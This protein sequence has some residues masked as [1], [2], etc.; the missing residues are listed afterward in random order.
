MPYRLAKLHLE[1]TDA[2]IPIF[3]VGGD[4]PD[5]DGIVDVVTVDFG[6][7]ATA[8]QRTQADAIIAAHD[9]TDTNKVTLDNLAALVAQF[10][11]DWDEIYSR[12]A[13]YYTGLS[14]AQR[15][16]IR[17]TLDNWGTATQAQKD[18][19]QLGCIC[20]TVLGREL[21]RLKLKRLLGERF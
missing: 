11:S 3:G 15:L 2:L 1:L 12:S 17:T 20:L 8:Q 16:A 14:P 4:D 9:S 6:P 7:E 13:A 5:G 21:D 18:T 19:A 10:E